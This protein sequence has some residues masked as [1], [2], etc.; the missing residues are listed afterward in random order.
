FINFYQFIDKVKSPIQIMESL[1]EEK[2]K[3]NQMYKIQDIQVGRE[4]S[5]SKIQM[6]VNIHILGE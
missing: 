4:V 6:N 1:I 5:P 2:L 3:N